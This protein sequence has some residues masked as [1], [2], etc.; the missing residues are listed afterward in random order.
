M[1]R[2]KPLVVFILPFLVSCSISTEEKSKYSVSQ[3]PDIEEV[4][5]EFDENEGEA[6]NTKNFYF[7]FDASGSMNEDCAGQRKI[8]GAKIAISKFIDKVPDDVN[9][10]LLVFGLKSEKPIKELVVLGTG[11]KAKFKEAINKITPDGSTPLGQVTDIGMTRLVE[12]YKKQ[13]GYGEYRLI[14]VT[15]GLASSAETFE[16]SLQNN[17]KYP[18][19]SLYGI[20]LCIQGNHMLKTY[21]LNYTD[22]NNYEELEEALT[23]TISELPDFDPES[24]DLSDFE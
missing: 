22:A 6:L 7:I 16:K 8:N 17:L 13:L 20:G 21:A 3:I 4:I 24:F 1:Q 2:I 12:Q 23:E 11:Q 10:G 15:D 9:I 19:V 5:I 18:F 14:I